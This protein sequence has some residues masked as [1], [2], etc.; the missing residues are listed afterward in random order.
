MTEFVTDITEDELIR[1]AK[2]GAADAFTQLVRRHY[3]QVH[4]YLARSLHASDVVDD[5]AQEV[6]LRAFRDLQTYRGKAPWIS[7]LMGIARHQLLQHLRGEA[8]RR[9]RAIESF[10]AAERL[11]T[12]E[13]TP[14]EQVADEVQALNDCLKHLPPGGQK[15]VKQHYLLNHSLAAIADEQGKKPGTIRMA[16]LRIRRGLR[17]CIEKRLARRGEEHGIS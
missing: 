12:V 8:R 3:R 4:N 2:A 17:N 1:C 5:L 7:W 10:L 14:P 6:F 16:L 11:N 13:Q 15:L 9:K